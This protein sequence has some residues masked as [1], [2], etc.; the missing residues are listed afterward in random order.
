MKIRAHLPTPAKISVPRRFLCLPQISAQ[1]HQ[2]ARFS[3]KRSM[4]VSF[5][6]EYLNSGIAFK[7]YR[8]IE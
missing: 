5:S 4:R 1:K 8:A 2:R 6:A 3:F 7:A